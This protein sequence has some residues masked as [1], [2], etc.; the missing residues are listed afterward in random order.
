MDS[1]PPLNLSTSVK[2]KDSLSTPESNVSLPVKSELVQHPDSNQF[3]LLEHMPNEVEGVV[4][5]GEINENS[6]TEKTPALTKKDEATNENESSESYVCSHCSEK[7][8]RA[9]QLRSHEKTHVEEKVH[10]CDQ[11]LETFPRLSLLLRHKQEHTKRTY[12]C[13]DCDVPLTSY[14]SFRQHMK[15]HKG[16]KKFK[17]SDCSMTFIQQS[18]LITHKRKHTGEKPF[19]CHHCNTNFKQ[20]SHLTT[21]LRTHTKDKPYSC[22]LCS[23]SFSQTGSL[24][25]HRRSHTGEKPFKCKK[26]E[27]VFVEKRNL[28]R[29]LLSHSGIRPFK[30]DLCPA[31]FTQFID[32]KRHKQSHSGLKPYKCDIC[33]AAFSRKNNLK[34]HK[35]THEGET[36][37][38][39]DICN[40][41]FRIGR[42]L[43]QHK[44][45]HL[46]TKPYS[47]EYCKASFLQITTLKRHVNIHSGYKPFSCDLCQ[48]TFF[49]RSSLKRHTQRHDPIK[50][51]CCNHCGSTF[52]NASSLRRH[53]FV[54][55][56]DIRYENETAKS[57][58]AVKC[59]DSLEPVATVEEENSLH[60]CEPPYQR[61]ATTS[62]QNIMVEG[63]DQNLNREIPQAIGQV[64]NDANLE[65][66]T[67]ISTY[68]LSQTG[69]SQRT[70]RPAENCQNIQAHYHIYDNTSGQWQ[71]WCFCET[72]SIRNSEISNVTDSETQPVEGSIQS[73]NSQSEVNLNYQPNP[74][75]VCDP[76]LSIQAPVANHS[77]GTTEPVEQQQHHVSI[78]RSQNTKT[79]CVTA[80]MF[81]SSAA[82]THL[83]DFS[84]SSSYQQ[85]SN[86]VN[87]YPTVLPVAQREHQ[88][89]LTSTDSI[90][91]VPNTIGKKTV[92][93][94]KNYIS[95]PVSSQ[96]ESEFSLHESAPE[97]IEKEP[98]NI[99]F[100]TKDVLS[101][102]FKSEKAVNSVC[103]KSNEIVSP[104]E[105]NKITLHYETKQPKEV[106]NHQNSHT[107]SSV[108][109]EQENFVKEPLKLQSY[110]SDN[111][112]INFTQQQ[113]NQQA[114]LLTKQKEACSVSLGT[115]VNSASPTVLSFPE[116]E[117]GAQQNLQ[118][119]QIPVTLYDHVSST[120][121]NE[122]T[123]ESVTLQYSLTVNNPATGEIQIQSELF[124][125]KPDDSSSKQPIKKQDLNK[126]ITV[127]TTSKKDKISNRRYTR[128]P[129]KKKSCTKPRDGSTIKTSNC[130]TLKEESK[131]ITNSEDNNA[132]DKSQDIKTSKIPVIKPV[133]SKAK[134][135]LE[136]IRT[137]IR[138]KEAA[139][140]R[141]YK[142]KDPDFI[143]GDLDEIDRIEEFENEIAHTITSSKKLKVENLKIESKEVQSWCFCEVPHGPNEPHTHTEDKIDRTNSQSHD[144]T[145]NVIVNND[146]CR[147]GLLHLA[148]PQ[149]SHTVVLQGDQIALHPQNQNQNLSNV[150]HLSVTSDNIIA[151]SSGV[152]ESQVLSN[153]TPE[154]SVIN[155]QFIGPET[156]APSQDVK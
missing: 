143:T 102:P 88:I 47:C 84:T 79:H 72:P 154:S 149:I 137:S 110:S 132:N 54:V 33:E 127:H 106:H 120:V 39:C 11:C 145:S 81:H 121:S 151:T 95:V 68:L 25:R 63:N 62:E 91:S 23:A 5:T 155:G 37:H 78:D 3:V 76:V 26:C 82:T 65:N 112:K 140:K 135:L 109:S 6:Q 103:E 1:A 125:A 124:P 61:S 126:H 21:H 139:E 43:K 153:G 116:N 142:P 46:E 35:L 17:C 107:V 113:Q 2:V 44:R 7:F 14:A 8:L 32:L 99:N 18:H 70:G 131:P 49:E 92:D 122:L 24:K 105:G 111:E 52:Q 29:H 12:E 93:S 136:P 56:N 53:K 20:V 117:K 42:D 144:M 138:L 27:A 98:E 10:T 119:Y 67:Q 118:E 100:N 50:P 60:I 74:Q 89:H 16:E 55:H 75:T 147:D 148:L 77:I 85:L 128:K 34:W 152:E 83:N 133:K 15:T 69:Q 71:S 123:K 9:N 30:C 73:V 13:P 40:V 64:V 28:Q 134:E 87:S 31:S 104:F 45:S 36:P 19:S 38:I 4:I 90:H 66:G 48:A 115:S 130:E 57:T 59:K 51:Y 80:N 101:V 129:V 141:K 86:Q 150:A 41:G 108:I 94:D 156:V 114:V 146:S 97:R 58:L 96:M 22:D